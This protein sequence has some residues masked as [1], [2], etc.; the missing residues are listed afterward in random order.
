MGFCLWGTDY[1]QDDLY[2]ED[3]DLVL[4]KCTHC[5]ESS[6]AVSICNTN[7]LQSYKKANVSLSRL[8]RKGSKFPAQ[9]S[10][11]TAIHLGFLLQP[12]R[13]SAECIS[14]L[15]GG[16]AGAQLLIVDPTQ[17]TMRTPLPDQA[18]QS[19]QA[20][21]KPVQWLFCTA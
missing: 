14:G 15:S 13:A 21:S 19:E 11:A 1:P 20:A 9:I 16:S 17:G 3:P 18:V 4:F 2:R 6:Y 5:R 12:N 7:A 10:S 8:N